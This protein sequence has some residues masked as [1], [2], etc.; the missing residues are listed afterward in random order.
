MKDE[1]ISTSVEKL[2]RKDC[3]R[4]FN[5]RFV[6]C[7][8][9]MKWGKVERKINFFSEKVARRI[10][11]LNRDTNYETRLTSFYSAHDLITRHLIFLIE[12]FFQS[13]LTLF[14]QHEASRNCWQL[15]QSIQISSS[16]DHLPSSKEKYVWTIEHHEHLII[17]TK[18]IKKIK[19]Y[20]LKIIVFYSFKEIEEFSFQRVF[21][22]VKIFRISFHVSWNKQS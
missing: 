18:I 6:R 16:I 3:D 7:R 19:I 8:R 21:V 17:Q 14:L 12:R 22:S 11:D 9:M 10:V 5:S 15:T 13:K 4:D 20:D 2:R 1:I